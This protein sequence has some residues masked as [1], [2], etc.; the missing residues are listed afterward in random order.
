MGV[1]KLGV[2]GWL[3][4]AILVSGLCMIFAGKFLHAPLAIVHKLL[5]VLCIVLLLR[6]AGALR[7][8][9]APPALPTAIVVFAVAYIASFVT[10][11]VQSIPACANSLW[12]NLHRIAAATAAI[13]CAVA[14]RLV[15]MAVRT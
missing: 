15:A 10:G 9:R 3:F 14:A 11:V 1:D 5:A 6:S 2:I 8:L 7:V 4:V 13:A 12:L